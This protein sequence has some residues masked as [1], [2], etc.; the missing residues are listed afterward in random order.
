VKILVVAD[1]LPEED[2]T[3]IQCEDRRSDPLWAARE[4]FDG[5]IGFAD[6][7]QVERRNPVAVGPEKDFRSIR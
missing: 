4:L 1:I 2:R 6:F 3:A 7:G 5:R